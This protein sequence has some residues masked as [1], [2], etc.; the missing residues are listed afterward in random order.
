MSA[1]IPTSY[2]N[3]AVRLAPLSSAQKRIGGKIGN[4]L[5]P[6]NFKRAQAALDAQI[7]EIRAAVE[8]LVRD[9]EDAVR[10]RQAGARDLIWDRAHD[11]RGLAGTAEKKSLGQAANLM[12]TY[13]HG[14]DSKFE[15][16]PN[17]VS[18]IAVV[19]LEAS[20]EGADEDQM[21]K[22]LLNETHE[23]VTVQRRREG[24]N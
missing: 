20:R 17:L 1:S 6:A 4:L 10:Q 13:L 19:A 21:V 18:T 8:A 24:R 12:C 9:L 16:D 7:P 15:P 11:I 5:T 2:A 23:A 3:K 14:T 22:M